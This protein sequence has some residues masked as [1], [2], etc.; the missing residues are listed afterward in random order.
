MNSPYEAVAQKKKHESSLLEAEGIYKRAM[1]AFQAEQDRIRREQQAKA[2][3]EARKQREKLEAQAAAAA[4]KGKPERAEELQT[5]AAMVAAPVI[6]ASTPTVAGISTRT[7]YTAEV[8]SLAVLVE[9][10]AGGRR[11]G[12]P[13]PSGQTA[14]RRRTAKSPMNMVESNMTV[15]NALAQTQKEGFDYPGCKLVTTQGISSRAS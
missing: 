12:A 8:T 2:E 9:A 15:L 5:K 3:K 11:M 7:T 4:A 14:E 6:A 13:R 10:I 1:I